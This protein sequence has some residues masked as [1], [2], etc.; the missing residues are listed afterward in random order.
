[1]KNPNILFVMADDMGYWS[2]GCAGNKEV[3]TPIQIRLE[4]KMANMVG[5]KSRKEMRV[6]YYGLNH[7][8]W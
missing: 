1:M 3:Q 2:M 8:G 7:F 5:L 4:E 6:G